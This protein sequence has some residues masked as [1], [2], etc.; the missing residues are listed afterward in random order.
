MSDLVLTYDVEDA[1]WAEASVRNCAGQHRMTVSYL[2]DSLSD[3]AEMAISLLQ[4]EVSSQA[5]LMDEPGEHVFFVTI[6][7]E[8][9]QY[10]LRYFA[11]WASMGCVEEDDYKIITKGECVVQHL[12]NQVFLILQKIDADLGPV[13][14]KQRWVEHDF[15]TEEYQYLQTLLKS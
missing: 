2:H 8:Q 6:N 9:A 14:Y 15:P 10:E 7:G 12:A 5:L 11:D 3:L 13:V 1:G 4:G